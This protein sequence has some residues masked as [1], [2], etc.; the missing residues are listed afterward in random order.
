M[1]SSVKTIAYHAFYTFTFIRVKLHK[2]IEYISYN[3]ARLSSLQQIDYYCDIDIPDNF[4]AS[5]SFLRVLNIYGNIT[6]ISANAF[7]NCRQLTTVNFPQTLEIIGAGA[8]NRTSIKS[9]TLMHTKLARIESEA[10]AENQKL[11]KMFLPAS[12]ASVHSTA[13]TRTSSK[14]NIFYCGLNNI[15]NDAGLNAQSQVYCLNIYP[16]KLFLGLPIHIFNFNMI[17]A[18]LQRCRNNHH[19]PLVIMLIVSSSS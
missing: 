6:R 3:F 13:F 12:L 7:Y 14:I 9:V 5:L 2:G 15:T 16:S 17:S 18:K 4:A 8:F 10:F 19:L 1:P 11:R